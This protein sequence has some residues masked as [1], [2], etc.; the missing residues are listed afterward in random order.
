[1]E[2]DSKMESVRQRYS[3]TDY[4]FM[5]FLYGFMGWVWEVGL[6][7]FRNRELVNRGST[8]GP[9]IPIYA[10]GGTAVVYLLDRFR[11]NK[12]KL[13]ILTAALCAA[14]EYLASLMLD[15]L[16]HLSYWNYDD[17]YFNIDGRIYLEGLLFFTVCGLIS[18]FYTAPAVAGF[19]A[20]ISK[21]NRAVIS[22]V[23]LTA[24][25]IDLLCCL[26][27]GFNTGA[28]VGGRE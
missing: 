27:F 4:L 7:I 12:I 19:A 9:W 1:M 6:H 10:V 16:F 25:F 21:K 24:L 15:V 8:Y 13:V 5:F 20:K 3:L 2:Y 11:K 22:A 26:L 28:G 17:S 18:I 14:L 23:L